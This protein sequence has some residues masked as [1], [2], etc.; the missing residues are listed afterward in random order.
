ML[1]RGKSK[2]KAFLDASYNR[3]AWNDP[4]DLP[5]WFVDDEKKHYRP[6]LPIPPALVMKMKE[7]MLALSMKPIKKVAEARARKKKRAQTKLVAAKK[8]AEMVAQS[9]DLSEAMKLK[10]I[11]KALQQGRSNS[12]AGKSKNKIVVASKGRQVKGSKNTTVVDKRL[13]C[14]T[15]AMKRNE[16]KKKGTLKKNRRR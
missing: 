6:Q 3:Y 5:D 10:A 11:S 12:T 7:Q 2:E 13:K 9:N 14:D 8:K 4:N 15:R 1:I 16:K